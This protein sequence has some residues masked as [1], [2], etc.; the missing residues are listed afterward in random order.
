MPLNREKPTFLV[1]AMLGN[2]AKKLRLLGYDSEFSSNMNDDELILKAEKENRIIITKDEL[3][4]CQA[5]KKNVP[6][7]H[8]TKNNEVEQLIQIHKNLVLA[9]SVISGT[10]ARCTICNGQLDSID[11]NQVTAKVPDGV[12]EQTDHFWKCSK[13]DRIYWEG[14]HIKNLQK[15]VIGL[16][17]KL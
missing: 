10:K 13:C 7:V 15:F 1:D 2:I 14:S 6:L 12:L 5:R 4:S 3:L 9:K 8:V 11:K 16:N 17:E